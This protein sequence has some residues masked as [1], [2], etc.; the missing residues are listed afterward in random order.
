MRIGRP[1]RA[2]DAS[3]AESFL[4][5]QRKV[6]AQEVSSD[7]S[8]VIFEPGQRLS[9]GRRNR[10]QLHKR[11]LPLA[12]LLGAAAAVVP[13]LA[14]SAT[15]P[16]TATVSGTE[17]ITWS[18][19]E[20]TIAPGGTVTFQDPSK[21][22]PHGIVWESG[23]ETPACSGVPIDEGRSNWKGTCTFAGEGAYHYYC[24]VHGKAMSGVVIVGNTA[25]TT[26]STSVTSTTPTTSSS[27][28]PAQ[29][30]MNMPGMTIGTGTAPP[31]RGSARDSLG[32]DELSVTLGQRGSVRGALVVAVAGSRL[33]IELLVPADVIDRG[34]HSHAGVLAGRLS[35]A[36]LPAGRVRFRVPTSAAA[37][38][39]LARI[40]RLTLSVR[41]LL[42][43]P[44]GATIART[45]RVVL[46]R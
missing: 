30:G 43:P 37:R 27:T 33:V 4:F 29:P 1:S 41:F 3:L 12:A 25:T 35:D 6:S 18:P 21:T 40:G 28:T 17:S 22:V 24:Y 31:S 7:A 44:G 42:T 13:S 14:S 5:L 9:G 36:D 38:S 8:E 34:R 39:A 20:V 15:T 45:L 19:A 10:M 23:P 2:Q 46:R 32:R 11:Y 16:Q 26:T